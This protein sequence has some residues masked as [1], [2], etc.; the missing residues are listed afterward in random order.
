MPS[1]AVISLRYQ[2]LALQI[3]TRSVSASAG[4]AAPREAIQHNI[5]RISAAIA[6]SI[7]A[8][9]EEHGL[10]VRLVVLPEYSMTGAPSGGLFAEWRARAAIDMHGPEYDEL[11]RIAGRHG[12]FLAGNAYEADENFPDLYFQTSFILAP[13]GEVVLR[14]R[15]LISLYSPSPY[16]V[17]DQ[18][19]AVYGTDALFPVAET[20]IGRLAAVASE[21]ILYP[22][23]ARC[24]VMRGA[25]VLVHSTSEMGSPIPTAKDIAK[26]ARA[27]E[28]IAYVVSANA[29]GVDGTALPARSTTGMAKILN[30]EGRVVAEAAPGGDSM[31][32]NATIDLEALRCRRRQ[33]GL[34]N[35]LVRQ[36]F[37][38][39]AESYRDTVF[40]AA[41]QLDK[42]A[43]TA[44]ETLRKTQSQTIERLAR[45]G[46]I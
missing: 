45:L 39:Y 22:E 28:N 15:R 41:G 9:G 36:P 21:E 43:S 35:V 25:E 29:A 32:A 34:S 20:P 13:S 8:I 30:Y 14:Y 31:A 1:P 16:D 5:S 18:Y 3:T 12:I 7:D 2:A 44:T 38:A 6:A 40:H 26:R 11:G 4:S 24:Q 10:A 17:W 33:A 27:A 46:L 23:I 37:Q 42:Y 19:L